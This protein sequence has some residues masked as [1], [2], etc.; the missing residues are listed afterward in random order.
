MPV[1]WR[2]CRHL[3]RRSV[4]GRF[5]TICWSP[6][7]DR[8]IFR[9]PLGHAR[10]VKVAL[11]ALFGRFVARAYL[12]NHHK[13]WVFDHLA[14]G[15]KSLD[16]RLGMSIEATEEGDWPDWITCDGELCGWTFAEAKGTHDR[17]GPGQALS[18]AW[19][20]VQR[21][22]IVKDGRTVPTRRIAIATRWGTADRV[23]GEPRM[24]VRGSE[25]E[26]ASIDSK[27]KEAIVVGL[28]RHHVANMIAKLVPGHG[29]ADLAVA[30]R[31]LTSAKD[32]AA[33]D[34]AK[35]HART[36]LA[37]AS[38]GSSMPFK[39]FTY[40]GEL[41][42]GAIS[43]AGLVAEN[44]ASRLH[45]AQRERLDLRHVFVGISKV[46]LDAVIEGKR[47][48]ILGALTKDKLNGSG[49]YRWDHAGG[50]IVPLDR[51]PEARDET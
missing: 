48:E 41:V 49:S 33:I 6:G 37:Q 44:S 11:S 26:C 13:L 1:C 8:F 27:D 43:R 34:Q 23:L 12:Q 40:R 25:D 51:P 17:A 24:S 7:V 19:K 28:L 22:K 18:R 3:A 21:V 35:D 10:E 36:L 4:P 30:I 47:G 16:G 50:W 5:S 20:Q 14:K 45:P 29:H 15:S 38:D 31:N 2:Y 42:G 46:V 39:K 32:T 9:E